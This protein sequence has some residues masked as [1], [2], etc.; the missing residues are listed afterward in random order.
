MPFGIRVTA[1]LWRP[2]TYSLR[3]SRIGTRQGNHSGG[4]RLSAESKRPQSETRNSIL[5][6]MS[7]RR[8]ELTQHGEIFITEDG[9]ETDLDIGHYERFTDVNLNAESAITS[10]MIYLDVIMRE[11]AGG[12]YARF[13]SYRISSMRLNAS[14]RARTHEVDVVSLRDRR[15]GRRYGR[16]AVSRGDPSV[17]LRSRALKN[18]MFI[19]V[20][21]Y[22]YSVCQMRLRRSRPNTA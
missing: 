6:S 5:T 22:R 3:A 9:A 8:L 1:F 15:H 7:I 10:G 2:S 12:N 21:P 14:L 16:P 13:R 11:R 20:T 4:D 18:C 19:H 17:V